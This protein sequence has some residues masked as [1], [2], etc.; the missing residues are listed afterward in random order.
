MTPDSSFEFLRT[1]KPDEFLPPVSRWITAGGLFLLA[2]FGSAIAL[3]AVAK[4]NVTV[5]AN[6]SSKFKGCRGKF[7]SSRF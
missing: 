5:R 4:Y 3:A 7:K 1:A 2:T 6:S